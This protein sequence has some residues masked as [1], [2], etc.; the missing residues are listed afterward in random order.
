MTAA[1]VPSSPTIPTTGTARRFAGTDVTLTTSVIRISSGVVRICAARVIDSRI[2]GD[3]GTRRRIRARRMGTD[4]RTSPRV[5]ATDSAKPGASAICGHSRTTTITAVPRAGSAWARREP[6]PAA[7]PTEPI[8]AARS[9]LSVG[10]T[11]MTKPTIARAPPTAMV[12]G[13]APVIRM[14]RT[15]VPQIN[16]KLLPETVRKGLYSGPRVPRMRQSRPMPSSVALVSVLLGDHV[17]ASVDDLALI[18]V[19]G[20]WVELVVPVDL[21]ALAG[22]IS[23]R[24][25]RTA[26]DE[27]LGNV[28]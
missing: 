19:E 24:L 2:A 18:E 26:L 20:D 12:R 4:H 9:T 7:S 3:S 27:A 22:V 6:S 8:T 25:R 13:D 21:G 16:E 14:P 1:A 10:R 23:L 28:R 17:D 5:A 11:R 15:T